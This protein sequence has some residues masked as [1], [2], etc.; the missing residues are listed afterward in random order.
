MWAVIRIN[1]GAFIR[2]LA[3]GAQDRARGRAGECALFVSRDQ[4]VYHFEKRGV[5]YPPP[6][7]SLTALMALKLGVA[8]F[9]PYIYSAVAPV[10]AGS[11]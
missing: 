6:T 2:K 9:K 3:R 10:W 11:S 4:I 1:Y 8:E 7:R 5:R